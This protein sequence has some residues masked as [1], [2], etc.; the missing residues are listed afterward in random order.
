MVEDRR[1]AFAVD[2][3]KEKDK[4]AEKL[5]FDRGQE[6]ARLDSRLAGHDER[7]ERI[8]GS[9]EK[10][11]QANERVEQKIAALKDEMIDRFDG[12]ADANRKA[13]KDATA[14]ALQARQ[15]SRK[16]L[17]Q[18]VGAAF[19]ATITAGGGIVVALITTSPT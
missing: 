19:I 7:F 12:L 2:L 10:A 13:E 9:V 8:N 11:A 15:D 1:S 6:A 4:L 18:I 5:A 17:F 14:L 3:K 16:Q